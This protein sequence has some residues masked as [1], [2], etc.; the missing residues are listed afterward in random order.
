MP[1]EAVYDNERVYVVEGERLRSI[2]V[3]VVGERVNEQGQYQV[4]IRSPSLRSGQQLM[5]TQL[6]SAI[7]GLKVNNLQT[8]Q[9]SPE[10]KG[11]LEEEAS[12]SEVAAV[13]G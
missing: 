4:L 8:I 13:A 6:S 12:K 10:D 3:E 5:T 7:T 11:T 1:I 9:A 2:A